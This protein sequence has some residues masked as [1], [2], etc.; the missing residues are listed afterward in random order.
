MSHPTLNETLTRLGWR[1]AERQNPAG[2]GKRVYDADG[3]DLGDMTAHEVWYLLRERG[4]L[5]WEGSDA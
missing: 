1:T 5:T 2:Q 4:L 3:N